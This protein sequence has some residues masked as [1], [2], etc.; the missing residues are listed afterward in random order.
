MN[1]EKLQVLYNDDANEIVEQVTQERSAIKNL[2]FLINLAM[3]TTDT[4][5]NPEEPKTFTEAWNHPK[6]N[7]CAKWQEVIKK[8]FANMNKQQVC[9]KTSKNL[10]LPNCRCMKN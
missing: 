6:A 5:P 7:S 10:I 3:V 9:H 4:K 8:E 2:K 1:H